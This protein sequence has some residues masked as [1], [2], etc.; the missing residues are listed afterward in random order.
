MARK[1]RSFAR[2]I[3]KMLSTPPMSFAHRRTICRRTVG[4]KTNGRP[5]PTATVPQLIW[6]AANHAKVANG[7]PIA[8]QGG[9][10]R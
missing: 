3:S 8:A 2:R 6:S 1:Q 7:R 10:H 9:P 4:C 5:A